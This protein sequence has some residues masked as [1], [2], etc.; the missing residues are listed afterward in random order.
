MGTRPL[1]VRYSLPV[2]RVDRDT[3]ATYVRIVHRA[4]RL[5]DEC[6]ASQHEAGGGGPTRVHARY[7]RDLRGHHL[8]LCSAH[9]EF[10]RERDSYD[11]VRR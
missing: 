9:A 11:R 5:C 3:K 8:D 1:S 4:V 10:W 2:L 7:T 6:I